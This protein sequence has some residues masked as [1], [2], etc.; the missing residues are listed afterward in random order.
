M[1]YLFIR[2]KNMKAHRAFMISAF[3][4]STLFLTS[5]LIYHFSKELGPTKFQ[6]EG[7]VRPAYF[8]ILTTHTILAIAIVPMVFVTFSR[9]LKKRFDP[10]RRIA[11]WTFP[12]WLYVSV[13][14][15]IVY[16]ML[17]QLY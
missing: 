1:G 11:R 3:C 6:G 4:A 15:V 16:L 12:I 7:I 17:Y 13:T 9:A 8:F 10:H 14:G 2:Q 5:Y